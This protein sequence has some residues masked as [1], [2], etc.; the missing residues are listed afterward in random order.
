MDKFVSMV[1]ILLVVTSIFCLAASAFC[2]ADFAAYYNSVQDNPASRGIDFFMI[3]MGHG[4][5]LFGLS[6]MGFV[7]SIVLK[8]I[9][10]TKFIKIYSI[11]GM[12]FF[13]A[14]FVVAAFIFWA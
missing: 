11:V 13:A 6:V 8:L 4:L 1:M 3:G 9:R 7:C 5:A 2:V 10:K 12:V 14:L